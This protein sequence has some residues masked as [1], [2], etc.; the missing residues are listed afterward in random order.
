MVLS[1]AFLAEVTLTRYFKSLK[2]PVCK[3]KFFW[4]LY[5]CTHACTLTHTHTRALL[6]TCLC[7]LVWHAY[8]MCEIFKLSS[9]FLDIYLVCIKSMYAFRLYMRYAVFCSAYFFTMPFLW[10]LWHYCLL[11]FKVLWY[12]LICE[13]CTLSFHSIS[14]GPRTAWIDSATWWR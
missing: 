5:Y 3:N 4:K 8:S 7:T 14:E 13:S 1:R 2:R 10:L 6:Y 9:S 12:R 11:L